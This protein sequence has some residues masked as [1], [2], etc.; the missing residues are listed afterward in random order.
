M[1]VVKKTLKEVAYQLDFIENNFLI[2]TSLTLKV[3]ADILISC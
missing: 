3:Q 2:G 1:L